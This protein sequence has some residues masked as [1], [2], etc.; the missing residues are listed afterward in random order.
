MLFRKKDV[1]AIRSIQDAF[2]CCGL[3][4]PVDRAWP[5]PAKGVEAD[6]CEKAFGRKKSCFEPWMRE[7]HF[8][9]WVV[10]VVAAAV[11][12]CQV[13]QAHI[14]LVVSVMLAGGALLA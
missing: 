1:R 14:L 11:F 7:E 5:F 13:R 6:A 10:I 2:A 3:R 9:G 4:S 8:V 12:V